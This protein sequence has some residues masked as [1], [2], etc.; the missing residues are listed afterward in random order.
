MGGHSRPDF[1][2][3]ARDNH[4]CLIGVCA[5]MGDRWTANAVRDFIKDGLHV[6]RYTLEEVKEI[7]S[8]E[9]MGCSQKPLQKQ[10][11]LFEVKK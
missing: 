8:K 10:P 11:E 7:L 5:D 9:E 3:I 2:Y 4:G 1:E 6:N